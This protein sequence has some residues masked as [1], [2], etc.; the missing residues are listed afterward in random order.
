MAKTDE[1]LI[2]VR[3]GRVRTAL[4]NAGRLVELIVEDET[5]PSVVG[6]IYLGRIE[7]VI[8]SLNAAFVDLG[9]N[10]SGFLAL[11]EARPR[12]TGG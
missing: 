7:K 6:N 10:R 12:N 2:E 8:E 11:A 5:R 9:L 4:I 1:V 3:P